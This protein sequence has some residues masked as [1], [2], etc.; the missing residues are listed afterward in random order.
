MTHEN[1]MGTMPV[2]KLLMSMAWPA[3]LS[4]TINAMYNVVDSI[5][6]SRIGED[7]LTAVSLVNPIQM[8]IIAISVGSGVGINSLIARR[9]GAKNQEAADKAASTSIRIGLFNYLIFFV[10]GVFFAKPFI[11]GY[12]EEGTFIF[13]SACQYLQIVCIGSLF[14]NIQ[15][16]L[17]KVLQSTGNMVAPMKCSL[18]GAIVNV[19][20]DPILIF[21][22]F[23]MPQMGV[24]GAALAT[25]IGQMCGMIMGVS[26]VLRGEHL[27]NI[28]IRGFKMDWKIVADIYKVGLPSIVM[29]SIASVMIIFYNMILV[30]YSTT[31][32]AVLGVYFRIQSFVFM[33]VFGLNQG[34]M[35][36]LGYNYGAKNKDRL[37]KTYKEAF[38]VALIVMAAGTL[39][40]QAIPAQLLLIFDASEEMLRIGV[41]ALRLIS[42]CFIPAAFGI[43]TGTLFQGTGH[44]VLSLYASVIRQL[45]G[46]LPLA[47]LLIKIG[48][49]TLSWLAFPL[50]E[51]L[52]LIYSAIM[53]RWLYKKEISKL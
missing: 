37:M 27:V 15:V 51:I 4:M 50:A 19:I 44:G 12:A 25:I 45:V 38:K 39:L 13:E 42:L 7:A 33:P 24:A 14:L 32:V 46:I 36:I 1:K 8:M 5:F 35:P 40:F 18:T 53:L 23:G 31:A 29:Q 20:L 9:L 3:I 10:I 47:Y 52:G 43:I 49:V 21:G 11:S 17:E 34:A 2:R 16:V 6:V 28:K 48:G 30:A 22:L 26:I 41:P